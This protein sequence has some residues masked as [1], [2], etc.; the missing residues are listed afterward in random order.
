L[1]FGVVA[2]PGFFLGKEIAHGSWYPPA[3]PDQSPRA[4]RRELERHVRWIQS[5][6]SR[7]AG[8]ETGSPHWRQVWPLHWSDAGLSA[9]ASSPSADVTCPTGPER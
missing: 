5:P 7:I 8:A 9:S 1:T 3:V 6:S 4:S 2:A